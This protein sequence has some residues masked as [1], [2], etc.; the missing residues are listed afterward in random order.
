MV[1]LFGAAA[2]AAPNK[3][4]TIL[5]WFRSPKS[6]LNPPV[7][8]NFKAF[9][10]FSSTFQ[11]K[12]YFQ[13]LFKTV[14]LHIIFKYF[15]S[16]CEP[17]CWFSEGWNVRIANRDRL[18]WFITSQSTFFNMPGCVFLGW[19][20]TKQGLMCLA[21]GHIFTVTPWGSNPQHLNLESSTLPL[22]LCAPC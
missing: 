11:D 15:S 4:T 16:L 2:Y 17:W 18:I 9:E 20:S 8:G 13:G 21:W 1:P 22:S 12:F 5:Y 19:T 14:L 7:N 10:C 6:L 3:G